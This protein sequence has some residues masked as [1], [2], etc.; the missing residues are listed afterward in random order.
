[1]NHEEQAEGIKSGR[2][3]EALI[4]FPWLIQN[5]HH[6][7]AKPIRYTENDVDFLNSR[8]GNMAIDT[9]ALTVTT[10]HEAG[11]DIQI[12]PEVIII[13]SF[14][15]GPANCFAKDLPETMHNN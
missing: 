5:S 13:Y 8:I 4:N 2:K 14:V 3:L 1:V 10:S 12:S 9:R 15:A 7:L 6:S 11:T